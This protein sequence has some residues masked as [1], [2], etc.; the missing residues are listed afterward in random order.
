MDGGEQVRKVT[1][2]TRFRW[3]KGRGRKSQYVRFIIHYETYRV[4]KFY[5]YMELSFILDPEMK[6]L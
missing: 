4:Y 2:H 3:G 5:L 1:L 6:A